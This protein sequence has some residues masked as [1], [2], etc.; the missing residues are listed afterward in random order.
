MSF[1]VSL[2][3]SISYLLDPRNPSNHAFDMSTTFTNVFFHFLFW[4]LH[5][6]EANLA[7]F[8]F[9]LAALNEALTAEVQRLKMATAELSGEKFQQLSISPQMF[10]LRQQQQQNQLNMH[11]IHHQQQQNHHPHHHQQQQQRSGG[12][13]P[14]TS[15]SNQ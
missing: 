14:T 10:Q 8:D 4:S 11:Q 12:N 15:E 5:L 2:A 13:T 3:F 9:Y 6:D 7:H 1:Q